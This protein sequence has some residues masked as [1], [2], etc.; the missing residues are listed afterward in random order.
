M[1]TP[2]EI[3]GYWWLP[4]SPDDTVAGILTYIPNESII[5]ELIGQLKKESSAIEEF[6]SREDEIVI[7]GFS[8]DAKEVS[9]MNCSPSGGALNFS[10]QFPIQRYKCQH[11]VIG[12]HITSLETP[13]FFKTQI[14]IPY[15]SLWATPNSIETSM[16]FGEKRIEKCC[17]SFNTGEYHIDTV[18]FDDYELSIDGVVNYVGEY[19]EPKIKQ[20][21][22]VSLTNKSDYSLKDAIRKIFLFEQFL[23]FATLA[24]LE[25]SEIVLYEKSKFQQLDNGEKH[26]FPIQYIRVY[27]GKETH[28]EQII[29]ERSSFL[30]TYETIKAEFQSILKKWF[31]EPA[32]IAPIRYHL[33]ECV[34]QKGFF[35]SVDF[36]IVIQAI[37]GFWWRFRDDDY[38]RSKH[39]KN[40][41]NQT[42]L[43]TILESLI[44]EFK[45]IEQLNLNEINV[46]EIV[47]SRHYFS[48]FMPKE[49]KPN[50]K[51]GLELYCLT[52]KIRKLLICCLLNFVGFTNSQISKI[53]QN[54]NSGYLHD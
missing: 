9:L 12:T 49:K 35:S 2:I 48:H 51:D 3:K 28:N 50:A 17:I 38:R 7:L 54:S 53:I 41:K 24:P 42:P 45:E 22:L 11:L 27:H 32:D 23:S 36:L 26:F 13:L 52:N 44:N 10:C 47:D 40:S 4:S 20:R 21:T 18:G 33:I 6:I 30:F 25:S 19:F 29:A 8:S 46:S 14:Q 1:T 39:Q 43:K 16:F 37:E 34:R 5:L 31:L 15:L